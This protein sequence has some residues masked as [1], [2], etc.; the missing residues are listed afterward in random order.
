MNTSSS[1]SPVAG[2]RPVSGATYATINPRDRGDERA[3]GPAATSRTSE[4]ARAAGPEGVPTAG[5]CRE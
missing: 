5:P 2:V 1:S 4:L 3:G